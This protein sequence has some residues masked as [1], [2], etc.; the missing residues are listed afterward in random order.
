VHGREA[1]GTAVADAINAD[2]GNARF[3]AADLSQ[4]TGVR[5]GTT[6]GPCTNP[7][8]P[9]G[10]GSTSSRSFLCPV[11]FSSDSMRRSVRYQAEQHG[12]PLSL[13]DIAPGAKLCRTS[14]VPAPSL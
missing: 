2:G 6:S 7:M 13:W 9:M 1:R 3:V 14:R 4:V 11:N 5:R 12:V 8:M 10:C